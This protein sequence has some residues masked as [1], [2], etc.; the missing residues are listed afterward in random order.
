MSGVKKVAVVI[1]TRPEAIKLAP[2]VRE[3]RRRGAFEPL[4]IS[5]G[6]HRDMLRQALGD[7]GLAPDVDLD[8]MSPGQTLYDV[9]CKSLARVQQALREHRP[10]WVV[11]QGDTTTAFTAALSAFY[12]Q[13]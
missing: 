1:G 4:V 10:A 8:I 12:E 11:V 3:I 9:T 6:Q 7:F 5:T 2:V 13:I